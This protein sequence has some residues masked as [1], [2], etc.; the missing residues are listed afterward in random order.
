MVVCK[1][2]ARGLAP[3]FEKETSAVGESCWR[4]PAGAAGGGGCGAPARRAAPLA[5][6]AAREFDRPRLP[7]PI[8]TG[9]RGSKE[10]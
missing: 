4:G 8:W 6:S 1:T 5:L 9:A 3:L 7:R 10:G 2:E